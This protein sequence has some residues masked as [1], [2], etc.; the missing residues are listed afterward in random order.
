MEERPLI[1]IAKD[2]KEELSELVNKYVNQ[3]P[4]MF[5]A[6]S[7]RDIYN[8]LDKISETQLTQAEEQFKTE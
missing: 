1:L 5:L 3:V 7:V 2:F 4:A 6:D 8:Q